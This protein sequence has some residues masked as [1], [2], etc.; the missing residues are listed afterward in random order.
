MAVYYAMY[1]L[2]SKTDDKEHFGKH[3]VDRLAEIPD[4]ADRNI[5]RLACNCIIRSHTQLVAWKQKRTADASRGC[6][7]LEQLK[8]LK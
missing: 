2:Y 1:T 8:N 6:M 3:V 7:T 5:C 4:E